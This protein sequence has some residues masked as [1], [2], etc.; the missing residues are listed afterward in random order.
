MTGQGSAYC[1]GDNRYGELGNGVSTDSPIPVSA[2]AG[3]AFVSIESNGYRSCGLTAAGDVYCWPTGFQQPDPFLVPGGIQF[4]QISLGG[5]H[6]CGLT[7]AGVAYCWGGND[8]GQLGNGQ[9][10][11]YNP[12]QNTPAPVIGGLTFSHIS[13][14][15]VHTCGI[16]TA[17]VAYCWGY[18][19]QGQLG[20]SGCEDAGGIPYPVKVRGQQ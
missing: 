5:Y 19:C 9:V 12:Q 18:N 8:I 2:A 11:G 1:W 3:L 7:S 6:A 4:S 20:V 17:G 15:F 14:G 16:T 10:W 13:A